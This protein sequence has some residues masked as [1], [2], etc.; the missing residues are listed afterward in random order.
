MS[1]LDDTIYAYRDFP[2]D[3]RVLSLLLW[4]VS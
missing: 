2:Q 4:G 3:A 1:F